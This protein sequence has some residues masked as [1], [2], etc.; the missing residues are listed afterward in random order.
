MMTDMKTNTNIC[1]NKP[2]THVCNYKDC[3]KR[4]NWSRNTS[5]R[6]DKTVWWW[7]TCKMD[8]W[9]FRTR[10]KKALFATIFSCKVHNV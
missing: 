6:I 5:K 7:L 3:G 10:F 1:Q 2:H 8:V 4:I 9:G